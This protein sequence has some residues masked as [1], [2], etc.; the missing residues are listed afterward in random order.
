MSQAG[1]LSENSSA[2][3][4]VETLTGNSGGAVGPDAAFNIDIQGDNTQGIDI[5]GTPASNLL[6]VSGIDAA[7]AR[8]RYCQGEYSSWFGC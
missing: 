3:P 4:D 5:V 6:T 2:L 1:L 7:T 8:Y